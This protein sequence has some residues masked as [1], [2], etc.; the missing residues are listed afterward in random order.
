MASKGTFIGI[1]V[2]VAVI[3]VVLTILSIINDFIPGTFTQVVGGA[4]SIIVA[5]GLLIGGGLTVYFIYN[6][7]QG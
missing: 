3:F 4:I 6:K 7:H 5:I 1:A 2:L